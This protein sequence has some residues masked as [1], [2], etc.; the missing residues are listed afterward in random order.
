M[1][2]INILG[3]D[4]QRDPGLETAILIALFS[5]KRAEIEEELPDNTEDRRG[6]WAGEIGSKWWLLS[7]ASM[8]PDLAG[9]LNQYAKEAIQPL[10]DDGVIADIEVEVTKVSPDTNHVNI[11]LTEPSGTEKIFKY[12]LNW[13]AEFLKRR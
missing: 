9:Q 10:I 7:R 8:T 13:E 11:K 3:Q 5:D 6:W 12:A 1:G 2:T 4:L